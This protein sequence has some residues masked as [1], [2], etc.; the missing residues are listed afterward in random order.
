MGDAP[1]LEPDRLVALV[2]DPSLARLWLAGLGLRDPE[3]AA[4]DL[5]DLAR[6]RLPAQPMARVLGLLLDLLPRSPDAGM[7]LTNFER[8]LA[9]HPE[10]AAAVTRLA[11][12][13]RGLEVLVQVLSTSQHFSEQIIRDPDLFAWLRLRPDRRDRLGLIDEVQAELDRADNPHAVLR[14]FKAREMLRIG[15]DDI[16]RGAPLEITALDLSRLAEACVEAAYRLARRR[17]AEK[18]GEARNAEGRPARFVVLALGKLGGAEL[19]YSSDIDLIFLY[20]EEGQT[21]GPRPLSHAEFFARVGGE[22]VRLLSDSTPLGQAYRVDMRL[23]PDGDQGPLARSLAA[24]LGYYETTGR[25]WERQALIKCR[26]IAGDLDLGASFGTVIAP[27]VYRRYLTAAEIAEIKAM[28]RRIEARTASAGVEDLEVKTGRGGIRD[29]EFVVQFLQLLHGG[30]YSEVRSPNTLAALARLERVGCLTVEERTVMEETYRF[31]RRVEHRLQTMFDLQTHRMPRDADARRTLA[32]RLGYSP[33]N[34]W[35]DPAGPAQRFL[36]DYRAKTELNREILNHLLHDAFEDDGGP[37][38]DPV[39]DLVLDPEPRPEAIEAALGAYPF[40]DRSTAYRNV[41]ALAREEHEFLSPARCRHFFAAIAPRL[42]QAIGRTPDPDRALNNLEKVSASLGAKAILW[43]LFNFLPQTLQLYVELCAS[44][45]FL[46][47]LLITNPGM[48]DE[49]M[50]SLV[51][52]RPQ[53]ASAIRAELAELCRG[54]EDLGPILLSFRNKEWVRIGARELMRRGPIAELTR[55][56]ADVAEAIVVQV[57]RWRW[58]AQVARQGVPR[59]AETGRRARWAILGLG[60]LGGRELGF[61]GDLDLV[62]L[63]EG[64]GSTDSGAGGVTNDQFFGDLVRGF[65]KTL[66]GTG[67]RGPLYPVDARLRPHGS[68]GLLAVP[69]AAFRAYFEGA[70]RPWER[71]ALTRARV[72]YAT[73]RF[74]RVVTDAIHELLTACVS[75]PAALAQ[76]VVAM[77]RKQEEATRTTQDLKRGLGGQADI[78]FLIQYLQL[79][80]A[81]SHPEILRP[82]LGHAIEALRRAGLI[83][84]SD[85]ETLLAAL[86]FQRRLESRL[87]ALRLRS[88][89]DLPD[90]PAVLEGLAR[91]LGY[92][93][94]ADEPLGAALR[95]DVAAHAARTRGLFD[96]VVGGAAARAATGAEP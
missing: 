94:A 76:E 18:H 59:L 12:D 24:T 23:R 81:A 48:I 79:V 67:D 70:A 85:A 33:A 89:V 91:C 82:N 87:R 42:L 41:M 13:A 74:G 86:D 60:K 63:Y 78:E 72:L 64:E 29:V 39:V 19:N 17:A 58:D 69:L 22:I 40:R 6:R 37:A 31:L 8:F 14:R 66:G 47:D 10:P 2:E 21:A 88:A 30:E 90:D 71:L 35:E 92:P 38:A 93:A 49:L 80:H 68:S 45:P 11:D 53:P 95:A 34:P 16:V 75:D 52:N 54:A 27:F 25:T 7:A 15:Y 32:V 55:E 77:R 20:D 51:V 5:R 61:L 4:R 65:L 84:A 43:E 28:K 83:A 56:L 50:D 57:A 9:A 96:R 36:A 62:C 44:S 3:R 73:G 46:S 26:A 1:S